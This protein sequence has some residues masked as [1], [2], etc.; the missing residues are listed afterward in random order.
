MLKYFPMMLCC[1]YI[2][3]V[4]YIVN[5]IYVLFFRN[6]FL[7]CDGIFLNYNWTKDT[8]KKS[9]LEAGSR[10]T[11]VYVGVDVFGRGCLGGGGFSTDLV[12]VA[13]E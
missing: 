8:L 4:V 5:F 12:C 3:T 6:F 11:D 10:R 7:G 9:V 13:R 1:K 2:F